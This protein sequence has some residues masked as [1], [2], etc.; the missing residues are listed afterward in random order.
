MANVRSFSK[1]RKFV[2]LTAN[3]IFDRRIEQKDYLMDVHRTHL[4]IGFWFK[5]KAGPSFNPQTY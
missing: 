3:G 5:F 1:P 4:K 2:R